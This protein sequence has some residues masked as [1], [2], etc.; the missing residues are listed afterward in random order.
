[1]ADDF[2]RARFTTRLRTQRLGRA[3]R[4]LERTVSTNDDAWDALAGAGEGAGAAGDGAAVVAL[5]QT[6]GRGRAGR[7]WAQVPGRGLALSVALRLHGDGRQAGVVP[8]VAGLAVVRT[9]HALGVPGARLKWPNDVLV[10]GR[11]LAGVLCEMRRAG[12]AAHAGSAAE[13]N[14]APGA[15]VVIGVG[16]NVRHRRDEFPGELRDSA[17]SLAL[18]GATAGLEDAAAEL[19]SQLEPLWDELQSGGRVALLAEW[20]RWCAHWGEW[21]VARTPA[22]TV[23]GIAQRLD[24]GGGLVLRT[25]SGV[26]TTVLA[27]DVSPSAAGCDAP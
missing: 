1:L 17:T 20:S 13:P 3:L 22:G 4:V 21:H 12:A 11:K 18:E 27:G 14:P 6:G 9:A 23:E 16:L 2:D 24:A 26:E 15:A 5:A 25:A 19:L 8:L 10:S 7:A